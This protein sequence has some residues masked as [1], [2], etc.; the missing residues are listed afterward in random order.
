MTLPASGAIT[1]SDV[2][3]ELFRSPTAS[4]NL[5]EAAVRTL[6]GK[7]SGA[8]SLNDLRGKT[9]NVSMQYLVIAGG[10]GGASRT[11]DSGGGGG[12]AGGVIQGTISA[13][14]TTYA[15]TVGAGGGQNASGAN[16]VFHTFTAIGGGRGG[17]EATPGISGGSG[18]GGG[19]GNYQPGGAGTSGQ[20]SA[21]GGGDG[22]WAPGGSGGGFN[23]VGGYA[24]SQAGLGVTTS[25]R[26]TS[27]G[28]AAG[29]RGSG[30]YYGDVYPDGTEAFYGAANPNAL[31]R[32]NSGCGGNKVGA[33]AGVVIIAYE[34]AQKFTGGSVSTTSRPGWTVHTFTSSGTFSR[35]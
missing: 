2:N 3:V 34:G 35:L 25:I 18:G 26:G 20:G 28:Y 5:N 13:P 22:R 8:V 32:A 1:L 15:I 10:G 14:A 16:S 27:E 11:G 6:A 30:G 12:G 7:A 19:A 23:N 33:A 29:G 9:V 24:A 21:G 17:T 4:I 31:P